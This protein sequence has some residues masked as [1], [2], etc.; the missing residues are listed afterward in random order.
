MYSNAKCVSMLHLSQAVLKGP[1]QLKSRE[2]YH[3]LSVLCKALSNSSKYSLNVLSAPHHCGGRPLLQSVLH[4]HV[5]AHSPCTT[6]LPHPL[7]CLTR[8][9]VGMCQLRSTGETK[10]SGLKGYSVLFCFV[11]FSGLFA[12]LFVCL[13]LRQSLIM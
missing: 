13:F 11:L 5:S 12:C 1:A 8:T 3:E 2:N 7:H 6:D 9:V 4:N 10:L